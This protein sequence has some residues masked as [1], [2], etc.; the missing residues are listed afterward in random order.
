[1]TTFRASFI[2]LTLSSI[3]AHVIQRKRGKEK[4]REK[5]I[6]RPMVRVVLGIHAV[7]VVVADGAP[8]KTCVLAC[9]VCSER[10]R[11][12]KKLDERRQRPTTNL[13]KAV[14]PF[15]MPSF[16]HTSISATNN[17]AYALARDALH[18]LATAARHAPANMHGTGLQFED[19]SRGAL[20]AGELSS[21]ASSQVI[22]LPQFVTQY[23]WS[24][25]C[26]TSGGATSGTLPCCICLFRSK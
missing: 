25:K 23:H 18:T 20:K 19:P 9:C 5:I 21:D 7:R 26:F 6:L 16:P 22:I 2:V 12:A 24:A 1:M 4:K 3:S 10:T 17:L 14:T 13:N 8:R 11:L 15:F